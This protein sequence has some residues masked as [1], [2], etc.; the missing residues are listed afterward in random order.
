M[1]VMKK[2]LCFVVASA[3][4][5]SLA[6]CGG[7]TATA[8]APATQAGGAAASSEEAA[9]PAEAAASSEGAAAPAAT[10][11][12]VGDHDQNIVVALDYDLGSFDN[13]AR[14]AGEDYPVYFNIYARLY[15][16][17]DNYNPVPSL[18]KEKNIISD[19]EVEYK[20]YEGAHFSDGSEI[21]AKDVAASIIRARDSHLVGDCYD[22]IVSVDPVD[23]Y[24]IKITTSRPY[25][26]ID[27]A[28][29]DPLCSI[30][31][32]AFLEK[33]E[34]D[35]NLWQ[36]PVCSG[37]YVVESRVTGDSIVLKPNEYWFDDATKA[38]ND[39]I[40]FKYVPEAATRTIM[41]QT[42]EADLAKG[43]AASDVE[44]ILNDPN[45]ELYTHDSIRF[46]YIYMNVNKAPFDNKFFRQAVNYAIDRDSCLLI[47]EEG[48]GQVV[49]DYVAPACVGYVGNPGGYSYDPAKAKE[50]I[51]QSGVVNP[52]IELV[53][54]ASFNSMAS[55][56]QANLA[57]VG[58]TCNIVTIEQ[59]AD[60]IPLINQDQ[61]DFGVVAWSNPTDDVFWVPCTLAESGIGANNFSKYANP[62]LEASFADAYSIDEKVRLDTYH[63]WEDILAEDCPWIPLY[64]NQQKAA[65]NADLKGVEM[66]ATQPFNYYK[67]TY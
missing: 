7:N 4:V 15:E 28:L 40:T 11:A 37:R 58:I 27:T 14:S 39:S 32:V 18:A 51:Q 53:A 43:L 19:T 46:F 63:K 57:D 59:M 38:Q 36:N 17:D 47:K 60:I 49:Y 20:I 26:Q 54:D 21:L 3:M 16:Y 23:D 48:Y 8:D 44:T 62:E 22:S 45:T 2:V 56:V 9:A 55:L 5:F 52:T 67:L 66:C 29:V 65:A 6:A 33:A 61:A 41:V 12:G 50:L 35:P 24:T 25:P 64:V 30:Q 34:A 10:G 1:K 31:S 13:C 42:G